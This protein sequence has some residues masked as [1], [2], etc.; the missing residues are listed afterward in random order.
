MCRGALRNKCAN[1]QCF[2]RACLPG[3]LQAEA[4]AVSSQQNQLDSYARA[5]AQAIQHG[6]ENA[7]IAYASAFA[8][9]V[10]GE[11]NKCF[12]FAFTVGFAVLKH[13]ATSL[14][15]TQA[16]VANVWPEA[17]WQNKHQC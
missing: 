4:F 1:P 10:A 11:T 14:L 7:T 15:C 5:V 9:A 12:K 13:N 3:C 6:G 2:L 17:S 8:Q 16:V